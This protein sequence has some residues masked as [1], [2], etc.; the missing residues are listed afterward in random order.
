MRFLVGLALLGAIVLLQSTVLDLV[1]VAGVKPDFVLVL[2]VFHAIL[3]GPREG[4]VLG[5]LGGLLIDAVSGYYFGLNALGLA[6]VGYNVGLLEWS[7]YR[8]SSIVVSL[9]TFMVTFGEQLIIYVL[10]FVL[11]V[12]VPFSSAII[13][14]ILPLAA[15]NALVA[16]VFYRSY[17]R[18]SKKGFLKRHY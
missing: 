12:T 2:V 16:A 18:V 10:L 13:G 9:M 6:I 17:A 14:L 15:Y 5:F 11:G 8:E 3:H 4:A 1:R 7:L